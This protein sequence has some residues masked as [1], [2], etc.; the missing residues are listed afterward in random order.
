MPSSC[1]ARYSCE[2]VRREDNQ[3]TDLDCDRFFVDEQLLG[4]VDDGLMTVTITP[5]DY[6][7]NELAPGKFKM[8]LCAQVQSETPT[9]TEVDLELKDPCDP[10]ASIT[11]V[12]MDDQVYELMDLT[13]PFYT[14]PEFTIVPDYC[15]IDYSYDITN[16]QDGSTAFL[17]EP[18]NNDRTSV[19]Q[20][21]K[22]D[23]PIRP[24]P[25]KQIVT[26]TATSTSKYG[27]T[28]VTR[29]DSGRFD[30]TFTDPCLN[31]DASTIT[32]TA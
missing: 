24:V 3:E 20:Y 27:V 31:A 28:G 21:M 4:G 18:Q 32:P 23:L 2:S 29:E 19:F 13:E 7:N 11:R 6:K 10:P 5:D 22:D 25:Q 16:L 30:L 1:P 15:P 9:C 17:S 8:N 12:P 26:V 14:H